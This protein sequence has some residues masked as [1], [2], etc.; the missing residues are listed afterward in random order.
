M[1]DWG[2]VL[3]VG[4]LSIFNHWI[5]CNSS[6]NSVVGGR[7]WKSECVEWTW[8]RLDFFDIGTCCWNGW[9]HCWQ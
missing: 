3:T 7:K 2:F 6:F 4:G 5:D 8:V 9:E 1:V